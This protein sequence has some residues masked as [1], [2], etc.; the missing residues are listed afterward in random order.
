MGVGVGRSDGALCLDL[1][2][3]HAVDIQTTDVSLHPW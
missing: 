1:Q 2:D 3:L